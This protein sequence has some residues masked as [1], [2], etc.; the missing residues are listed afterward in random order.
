MFGPPLTGRVT[1]LRDSYLES[2]ARSEGYVDFGP[3]DFV[4]ALDIMLELTRTSE[5]ASWFQ[6]PEL[7]KT[8]EAGPPRLI[9]G[10]SAVCVPVSPVMLTRFEGP[11]ALLG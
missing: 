9:D 6:V 11:R 10:L 8:E 2:A 5:P 4:E 3:T 7:P 1:D